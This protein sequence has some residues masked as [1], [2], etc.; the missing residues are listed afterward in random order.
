MFVDLA[1]KHGLHVRV[2]EVDET[3]WDFQVG[4]AVDSEGVR[5]VLRVPRRPEVSELIAGERRLLEFL[6][7][8]LN[9]ALPRWEICTSELVAYRR[10]PDSPLGPED[11]V[12]LAYQWWIDVPGELF[13]TLGEVVAELH[14]APAAE[15]AELG[16]PV[17]ARTALRSEADDHLR[18]GI[19]EL[20]VPE[21]RVRRWREW[22]DD[23]RYWIGD[24]AGLRLVHADLHPGHL[25]VDDS[26]ML[27][28]ILDWT[29]AAVD[30]PA[31][32]FI[33]PRWAFGESGL[34]RLLAAY[35]DAGG[36]PREHFRAHIEQL[37]SFVFTVSLGIHGIDTG[38]DGYVKIAQERLRE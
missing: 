28:G 23:D 20:D 27:T 15:I 9:V 17:S 22:I 4:H 32:D 21:S 24:S 29:D 31:L 5:W 16:V 36:R 12:T 30:D 18:R 35:V 6:R 13:R 7:P 1:R 34:D 26:G 3:G 14:R 25:L 33:A 11:P 2:L 38:H 19:S 8:R 37:A 10:L